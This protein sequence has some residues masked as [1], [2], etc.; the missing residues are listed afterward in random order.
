MSQYT[1][2]VTS[3][4]NFQASWVIN[5]RG[6]EDVA[7]RGDSFPAV[8]GGVVYNVIGSGR[9]ISVTDTMLAG[10]LLAPDNTLNQ[11]GGVIVGKVVA[12]DIIFSLQINKQNNCPNPGTVIVPSTTNTPT[13]SGEDVVS[14][15]SNNLRQGD[16]VTIAGH[17]TF[18]VV[19]SWNSNGGSFIKLSA[20]L[21]S[22][23]PAG[24][25]VYATINGNAGRAAQGTEPSS[26]SIVSIAVA[27]FALIALFI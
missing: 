6:T 15:E 16:V 9:V 23:L 20:A 21:D 13:D 22:D 5:V 27:L 11:T 7:F 12:G 24:S 18:D 10:H 3:N 17:G 14:L 4:C 1:Y 8:P 26:A 2:T 19:E 25:R